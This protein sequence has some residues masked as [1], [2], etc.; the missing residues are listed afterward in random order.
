MSVPTHP[1]IIKLDE[2]ISEQEKIIEV[3]KHESLS[4]MGEP[5]R[6]PLS[7][8]RSLE[9]ESAEWEAKALDASRRMA[10][11]DRLRQDV[12]RTQALY[13]RL[14]G[15]IQ[16]VDVGARWTRRMCA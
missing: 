9:G 12:Q 10:A 6:G 13:E 1:K 16:Q 8:D 7:P 15:V 5:P 2:D 14:V 3:F 11:Y 4:Q